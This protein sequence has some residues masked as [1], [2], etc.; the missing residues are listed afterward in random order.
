MKAIAFVP[1]ATLLMTAV[2]A[3]V[4]NN[5]VDRINRAYLVISATN[6]P[7]TARPYLWPP[8][9]PIEYAPAALG[10]TGGTTGVPA[11]T[12]TW[13]HIIGATNRRS[14]ARGHSGWQLGLAVSAASTVVSTNAYVPRLSIWKGKLNGAGPGYVP[15]FASAP[16]IQS[17]QV[18]YTFGGLGFYR[19]SIALTS[20]TAF[21]GDNLC[22][23]LQWR[24]GEGDDFPGSQGLWSDY[25]AGALTTAPTQFAFPY[26]FSRSNNTAIQLGSTDFSDPACQYMEDEASITGYASWGAGANIGTYPLLYGSSQHTV[27]SN[28]T[29]TAGYFGYDIFGGASQSG[30]YALLL[31]NAALAPF[32]GS[33]SI[34]GQTVELN[35]ADPNLSFL[36]DIGYV[37][38]LDPQ[39]SVKGPQLP[40][41][42]T[43]GLTGLW[44]GAEAAII[45]S[46][47]SQVNET[48]QATWF[49]IN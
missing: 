38:T 2:S 42:V 16:L 31:F 19:V 14:S 29:T 20:A 9:N 25:S 4:D 33:F 46:N 17:A 26:G 47:L 5:L 36:A 48:T 8:M 21:T 45:A 15:D 40:L 12:E 22:M 43:P 24:G 13:K 11:G 34:L 32:P 1:A 6:H 35:I 27:N 41:P 37:L 3:Q 18:P 28:I 23:S 39:G 49:R 7:T 10:G 44:I 30:N